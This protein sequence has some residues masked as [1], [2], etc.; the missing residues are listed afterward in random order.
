[1]FNV[2]LMRGDTV[3]EDIGSDAAQNDACNR[4][5]LWRQ[6]YGFEGMECILVTSED[7]G[8]IVY[9]LYNHNFNRRIN[10]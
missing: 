4:A 8:E 9:S 5:R 6:A 2:A 3:I 10:Q 7:S 1:M